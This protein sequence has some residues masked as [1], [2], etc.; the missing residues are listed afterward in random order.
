VTCV[1]ARVACGRF[2]RG[3]HMDVMATG[4][5]PG[6]TSTVTCHVDYELREGGTSRTVVCQN[7]GTWSALPRCQGRY[8]PQCKAIVRSHLEYCSSSNHA[9]SQMSHCLTHRKS[10]G[11]ALF[12]TFNIC[13]AFHSHKIALLGLPS[14]R[15]RRAQCFHVLKVGQTSVF[16]LVNIP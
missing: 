16:T 1:T 2:R 9:T 11:E 14:R 6:D 7:D 12:S 3:Q 15:W 8:N 5:M 13:I 4:V 10:R